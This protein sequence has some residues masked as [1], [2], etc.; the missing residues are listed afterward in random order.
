M[1][2]KRTDDGITEYAYDKA[3]NLLAV[4][5]NSN[6]GNQ[7]R[8]DYS[9]DAVGQL[10]SETNSARELALLLADHWREKLGLA[11]E[12][13]RA[14]LAHPRIGVTELH[15][16]QWIELGEQP[17]LYPV[18]NGVLERPMRLNKLLKPIRYDDLGLLGFGQW[19]GDPNE[20]F[21]DADSRR[22]MA[23]SIPTVIGQRRH[24]A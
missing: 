8:L 22:R 14:A 5:F 12:Q 13:T 16:G 20:R 18:E 3:D 7:Q 11:R 23:R 2:R 24:R 17:D 1:V 9:Y 6:Q 10:L 21:T 15:S 19:D 4:S